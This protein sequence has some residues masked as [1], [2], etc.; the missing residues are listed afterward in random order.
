MLLIPNKDNDKKVG[1]LY[2]ITNLKVSDV[3]LPIHYNKRFCGCSFDWLSFVTK[4][5]FV[6]LFNPFRN[7]IINLPQLERHRGYRRNAKQCTI[8]KLTLS[9]DPSEDSDCLVVGIFGEYSNLVFMK[10]GDESWTYEDHVHGELFSNVLYYKGQVLTIDHRSE[11]IS[12]DV[13][14]NQKNVLAPR[15]LEY[16]YKTYLVETSNK[17]LLQLWRF[18]ESFVAGGKV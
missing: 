10:L 3:N 7:K 5:S 11:L 14:I 17:D 4:S 13:S 1:S 15:D 12:L 2:S 9:P 16:A 8:Q 6:I 18:F